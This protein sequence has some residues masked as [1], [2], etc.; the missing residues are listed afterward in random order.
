MASTLPPLAGN[1][2]RYGAACRPQ[3][4]AMHILF[5]TQPALGHFHPLVPL[6]RAA[7]AAGHRVTFAC[8]AAFAPT[9]RAAGFECRPAGLD[10]LESE[11]ERTFPELSAQPP[12]A[13]ASRWWMAE[14]FGGAAAR[15]MVPD[16]LDLLGSAK[17]PDL[18][19]RDPLEFGGC[20]AAERAGVPHASAGASV[21]VPPRAWRELLAAPLGALRQ[22]YGLAPDPG[23]A[24]TQH[25][26]DLSGVPPALLGRGDYIAPVTHFL[27]PAPFDQAGDAAAPEWLGQASGRP[28]VSA[29]LGT[30]YNRTPGV[31]E[32]IVAALRDEPVELA[33]ALGPGYDVARLGALPGHIH[34][35]AYLPQ[36][37][38]FP[39]CALAITHGGLNSVVAALCH[40]LPMVVLP[41]GADQPATAW[42]CE[43]IGVARVVEPEERSPQAI[44]AAVRAVLADPRYRERAGR[45][46]AS[47]AGLPGYEHGVALLER[48]ARERQPIVAR[49]RRWP[50]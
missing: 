30:V 20:V 9:V 12:G 11:A 18:L 28:L 29:S 6:A 49:R 42:R 16:L 41:L 19:V 25:Y 50:W 39:R 24:M 2:R 26:L 44:R 33:L 15:R 8:A 40:G 14:I 10:W 3:E 4:C 37:E 35:A 32:Q 31:F 17:R 43:R 36:T 34:A 5:T 22:R 1:L 46:R 27:R 38:L 7:Q 23:L 13:V 45:V 47:L 21:F 48:L